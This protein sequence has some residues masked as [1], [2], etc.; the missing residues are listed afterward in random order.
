[1]LPMALA[2]GGSFTVEKVSQHAM[3]NADVISR[4]LPVRFEF[5]EEGA[6]ALCKVMPL[7]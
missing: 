5:S 2:G 6:H 7:R 1:M 4:F 3:T